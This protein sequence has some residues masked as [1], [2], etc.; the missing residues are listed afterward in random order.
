MSQVIVEEDGLNEKRE[1]SKLQE[2]KID[3]IG[4]FAKWQKGGQ[5]GQALIAKLAGIAILPVALFW[6]LLYFI[7]TAVITVFARLF[8]MLGGFKDKRK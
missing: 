4:D 7:G 6:S 1:R 5:Q 8:D 3:T 2:R